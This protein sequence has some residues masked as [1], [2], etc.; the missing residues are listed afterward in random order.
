MPAP[1]DC[2]VVFAEM[3]TGSN[4]LE[5]N[6]NALPG[7]RC[8][9]EVFNPHFIGQKGRTELLGVTLA[10]RAADP[11]ELLRRMIART[12]GLP[13]F[14]FFHDHDPRVL[15]RILPDPRCAK[16]I[17]TRNPVESFVSLLIAG[18]TGQWRLGDLRHHRSARVRFDPVAFER[19]LETL[20]AFQLRLLHGL[21]TTGQTA[22]HLA[23]ED[24][25]DV[26]VLNGLAAF[27]G[28]EARLEAPV[29]SLKKQNPEP[30]LERVVN[31]EE[32][33]AALARLDRF[34]LWR[35]PNFEPRRGPGV[36]GFVAAARAPLLYMP[37]RG[38]PEAAVRAWLAALDGVAQ[39]ALPTDFTQKT[40]R[41][42]KRDR[43][44]HRAFTVLRH[45]LARAHAA[46]CRGILGGL[47]PEI[48][49]ILRES[50]RL[51]VPAGDVTAARRPPGYDAAAHRA[52]FAAFL[53]FLKGNLAGQTSVR[54]DPLWASQAA[55]IQGFA[56]AAFPDR[57]IR[58]E[59][60]GPGLAGLAAEVGIADAPPP[61][62]VEEPAPVPLAA[63]ADAELE[64]LAREAYARDYAAFGFPD[65]PAGL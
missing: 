12:Q 57:L 40:L 46:Y 13:G 20:Q 2:F 55:V 54:V 16:I 30:V 1:F 35:T 50:Y 17:L 60:L 39:E 58:E 59:Q 31:P 37:V 26:A 28:V 49:R 47:Y 34:N 27:L 23:Y 64:A 22:F 3:R 29:D 33:E 11:L 45:P 6:L 25:Q 61:P 42:W 9:G 43:P 5:A 63:I 10:M 24:V 41:Q 36:P 56:Q 38:G 14:R 19:H 7:V 65:R 53:R 21:Q 62:A 51:P 15:E 32:M 8:Y 4:L 44:G 48:R 52:G 18:E